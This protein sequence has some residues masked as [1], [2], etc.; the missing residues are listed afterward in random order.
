MRRLTIGNETIDFQPREFGL[1][2]EV[3][4][5]EIKDTCKTKEDVQRS[6]KDKEISAV[7]KKYTNLNIVID[8]LTTSIFLGPCIFLPEITKGHIFD[9]MFRREYTE[10]KDLDKTAELIKKHKSKNSV[11]LTNAKVHGFFQDIEMKIHFPYPYIFQLEA[12]ECAGVTLH[13]VGHGF[14]YFEYFDRTI[15]NNQIL[16]SL[17][18][19]LSNTANPKEKKNLIQ[20]AAKQFDINKTKQDEIA[21]LTDHNVI[22]LSL[23]SEAQKI[24][25]SG[26]SADSAHYDS[27]SCEAL[28]DQFAARQGYGRATVMGLDKLGAFIKSN[29][30]ILRK[31][32]YFSELFNCFKFVLSSTVAGVFV[33]TSIAFGLLFALAAAWLCLFTSITTSIVDMYDPP[34]IR[35]KRI[36]EQSITYLKRCDLPKEEVQRVAEDIKQF[37]NIL[38]QLADKHSLMEKISNFLISP[39]SSR[40]KASM[41]LQRDLE[42]LAS[43]DLYLAAAKMKNNIQ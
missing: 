31:I 29:N 32:I 11:D 14:T 1:A 24:Q 37:D 42:E 9:S 27:V 2:L 36:R 26:F 6:N 22:L 10:L 35:L 18:L 17:S 39:A 19:E 16:A 41:N 15:R 8:L 4:F 7:I 25:P 38:S 43:N 34:D 21:S 3:I 13:E 5:K 40:L 12:D 33:T 23:L 30:A 20:T 28:A